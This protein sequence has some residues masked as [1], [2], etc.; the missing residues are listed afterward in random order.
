MSQRA[1]ATR[2]TAPKM[3]TLETVFVLWWKICDIPPVPVSP[4]CREAPT[5]RGVGGIGEY[6]RPSRGVKVCDH[7]RPLG[8][9]EGRMTSPI[10]GRARRAARG[11]LAAAVAAAAACGRAPAPPE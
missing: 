6:V 9:L 8:S 1:A 11:L 2:N 7:F 3:L 10:R 4:W 5:C